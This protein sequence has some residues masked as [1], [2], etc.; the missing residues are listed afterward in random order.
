MKDV[1]WW[2]AAACIRV[3]FASGSQVIEGMMNNNR[4]LLTACRRLTPLAAFAL[5]LA[6]A[7]PA[8]QAQSDPNKPA[9]SSAP[10]SAAAAKPGD[11]GEVTVRAPRA[12]TAIG[13]PP[14]K[15]AALADEAAKNEAWRK[16]RESTPRLTRDP[17]DQSKDFPGLQSYVPH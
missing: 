12:R 14:A 16:Y 9:A 2:D 15:A 5:G 4:A 6:L 13:I 1:A 17:N 8:A 10:S 11:P 3:S 7:A